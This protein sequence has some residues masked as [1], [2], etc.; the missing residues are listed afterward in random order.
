MSN[1]IK[2]SIYFLLIMALQVLALN[3]MNLGGYLNPY[4]Y[5]LFLLVLPVHI[6]KSLLLLL[7]FATGLCMDY[8]GNTLGLHASA[9][10]LLAFMRP[11]VIQLFFKNLDFSERESPMISRVGF[12]G[13]LK[14]TFILVFLHHL[15]LFYLEV[16]SF[17]DG[18]QTLLAVLLSSLL[19]TA[20]I[21]ILV[22]IFGS[23]KT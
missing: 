11:S 13:F 21:M 16:L 17:T 8:F 2:H 23:R 14:Y 7:G 22:L 1:T 19:S 10:V 5:V 15:L 6:N 9:S 12:M 20:V 3:H 4:V 18:L